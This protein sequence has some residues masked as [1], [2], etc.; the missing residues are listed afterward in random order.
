VGRG[1]QGLRRARREASEAELIAW[2]K[3]RKGSVIAPKHVEVV[4]AIPLTAVGK[5]DKPALRRA[6]REA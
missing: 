1:R 2:V 6:V 5:H 3:E 4:D